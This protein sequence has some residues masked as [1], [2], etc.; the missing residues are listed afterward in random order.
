MI[1]QLSFFLI[2]VIVSGALFVSACNETVDPSPDK[3][4]EIETETPSA[5]YPLESVEV[6]FGFGRQ[7][8]GFGGKHHTADDY[9]GSGGTPVFAMADGRISFSGPLGGY[10]WLITIDHFELGVY[11]LYGHL[12][13]ERN[14]V[15]SGQVKKGQLIAFLAD[16]DE[17]GSG[18]I[19]GGGNGYPYWPP[20]LHFGIRN[21]SVADY[22]SDG[23]GRWMAGYTI[24]DPI[25]HGWLVPSEFIDMHSEPE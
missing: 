17:D 24:E 8:S 18:P 10:G 22:P 15:T 7:S 12:S 21:G 25:T 1:K 9:S 11:S 2:F 14:K 20:H 19:D 16:D 13:T 5:Q 4:Q 3:N 23:E 6:V